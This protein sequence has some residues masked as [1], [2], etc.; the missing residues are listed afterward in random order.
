MAVHISLEG[1][2]RNFYGIDIKGI[3]LA[4]NFP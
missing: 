4:I 2:I 3:L 1:P